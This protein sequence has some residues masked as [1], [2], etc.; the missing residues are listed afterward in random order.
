MLA[1]FRRLVLVERVDSCPKAISSLTVSEQ[2]RA[3][4]EEF[5]GCIGRGKGLHAEI[6]QGP[7]TVI[8]KLVA[9]WSDQCHLDCFK[10][11]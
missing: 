11:S 7:L 4:K 8:L 10:Y 3:F 2:E 9:Q 1:L 6:A 5:L